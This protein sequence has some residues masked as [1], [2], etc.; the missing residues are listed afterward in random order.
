[1]IRMHRK[2]FYNEKCFQLDTETEGQQI[3]GITSHLQK[4]EISSWQLVQ[5]PK[6]KRH[7]HSDLGFCYGS[8]KYRTLSINIQ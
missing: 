5:G 8:L 7:R 3:K 2:L 6:S 4:A 1:M